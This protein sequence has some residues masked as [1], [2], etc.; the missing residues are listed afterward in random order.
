M[1]IVQKWTLLDILEKESETAIKSFKQNE[2]IVNP[3]KFQVMALGR[4]KKKKKQLI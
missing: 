4:H 1:P 2:I 3:D